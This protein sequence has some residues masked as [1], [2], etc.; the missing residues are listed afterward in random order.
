MAGHHRTAPDGESCVGDARGVTVTAADGC[1]AIERAAG[2][3]RRENRKEFH[4]ELLCGRRRAVRAVAV[5]A[6]VDRARA[7]ARSSRAGRRSSCASRALR[8]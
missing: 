5:E 4:I 2:R 1:A 6:R 7:A 3:R 8:G